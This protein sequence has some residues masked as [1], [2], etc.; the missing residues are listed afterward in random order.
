MKIGNFTRTEN[1]GFLGRIQTLTFAAE[2]LYAPIAD[3][4][5]ADGPDF[6]I[7][8]KDG[9]VEYGA[10]WHEKSK[11]NKPYISGQYD[12]PFQPRPLYFALMRDDERTDGESFALYWSRPKKKSEKSKTKPQETL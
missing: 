7:M 10:G 3:K 2:V 6:R 9:A 11:D 1:G 5:K 4:T 8:S 12:D